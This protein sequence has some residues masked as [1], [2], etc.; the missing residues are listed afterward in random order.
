MTCTH[1]GTQIAEKALICYRCGRPTAEPTLPASSN[2][3][4]RR[5]SVW[6]AA[7]GLVVVTG[8]GLYMAT[9]QAARLPEWV[10]WTVAGSAA[11]VLVARLVWRRRR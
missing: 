8:A 1:C 10:R 4:A 3:R 6:V 9:P 5:V 7:I 2:R 11:A